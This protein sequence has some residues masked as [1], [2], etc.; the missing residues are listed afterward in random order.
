[1][2]SNKLLFSLKFIKSLNINL[3]KNMF[4]F[5]R[6][7]HQMNTNSRDHFTILVQMHCSTTI[8]VYLFYYIIIIILSYYITLYVTFIFSL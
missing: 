4:N 1:M 3:N 2:L 7:I 5:L 6:Q 8:A